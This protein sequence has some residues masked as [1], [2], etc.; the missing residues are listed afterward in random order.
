[1]RSHE[2]KQDER[3]CKKSW[4]SQQNS[5]SVPFQGRRHLEHGHERVQNNPC[6]RGLGS[7]PVPR[8]TAFSIICAQVMFKRYFRPG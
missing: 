5:I 3:N 6:G 8:V 7:Q 1:M 4:G 2:V